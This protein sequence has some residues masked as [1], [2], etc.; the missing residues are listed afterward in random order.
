M[1]MSGAQAILEVLKREGVRHPD[2]AEQAISLGVD[3]I[4][5]SNHGGRQSEA[6]PPFIDMLPSIVRVVGERATVLFDSGIRSGLDV[7]RA[8]ALGA[9]A[10]F[11]GRAF[12][13]GLAA[14][15]TEGPDHVAQLLEE[16]LRTALAQHGAYTCAQLRNAAVLHSA[17]WQP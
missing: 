1:R 2:D 14:L 9:H 15:G 11:C 8:V 5:V 10:T 6:A 3:G 4:L 16:E 12:L 17:A 7:A 13:Y